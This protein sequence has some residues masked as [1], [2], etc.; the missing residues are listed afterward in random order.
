MYLA[1]QLLRRPFAD[2]A[3]EFARDHTTVLLAW[4]QV[5]ARLGVDAVLAK[6]VTEVERRLGAGGA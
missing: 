6:L 1:R 4:R 3:A 2:L 5:T